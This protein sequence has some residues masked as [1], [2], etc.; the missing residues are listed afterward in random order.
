[1]FQLY[2]LSKFSD[3]GFLILRVVVGSSYVLHGYPKMTGGGTFTGVLERWTTLGNLAGAPMM[4]TFFG[5]LAAFAEF[6]GGI[7][8]VLGFMTRPM[9]I[10]LLGTMLGAM[11]YHLGK[12]DGFSDWSHAA[13]MA[14][15]FAGLVFMGPGRYSIDKR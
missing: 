5:F 1:M 11:K 15:V 10:L 6:A 7:C 14:G 8:L 4:P 13:E 12:G 2:F 3:F 9:C